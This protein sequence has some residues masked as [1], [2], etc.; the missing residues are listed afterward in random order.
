MTQIEFRQPARRLSLIVGVAYIVVVLLL[1]FAYSDQLSE[2][3]NGLA[4]GGYMA[5]GFL[6]AV[7]VFIPLIAVTAI[8]REKVALRQDVSNLTIQIGRREEVIPR[9]SV[10]RI[11][12][13]DPAL[14][15]VRLH[16]ATGSVLLTLNPPRREYARVVEFLTSD[17]GYSEASRHAVAGGR[18]TA[19]TYVGEAQA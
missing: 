9:R 2:F 12:A 15:P 7:V 19:I 17:Y 14:G 3:V 10:Q 4:G 18:M 11:V 1:A 8:L 6:V 13:H 5:T 16:S